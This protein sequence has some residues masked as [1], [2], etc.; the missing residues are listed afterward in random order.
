M[1]QTCLNDPADDGNVLAG[2]LYRL[3]NRGRHRR[4]GRA[5]AL[6]VLSIGRE[7][8]DATRRSVAAGLAGRQRPRGLLLAAAMVNLDLSS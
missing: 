7:R 4:P 6:P 3:L 1:L 5:S 8:E 2:V